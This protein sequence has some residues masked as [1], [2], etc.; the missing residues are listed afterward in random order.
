MADQ[1]RLAVRDATLDDFEAWLALFEAVAAE[2][3]WIGRESPLDR[4]DR[5]QAFQ[6]ALASDDSATLLAEIDGELVGMLGIGDHFGRAELGMMVDARW[7]GRGVGSK[8]MEAAIAWA[9]ARGAHKISLEV[10]PHNV[11]ARALYE[12]FGFAEEAL[13]RRHYRRRNGELWDAVEMGLVLDEQ[14]PGSPFD[15]STAS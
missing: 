9:N 8:L 2:G 6:Q 11:A 1:G 14:S 4:Q 13:L 12:K 10:W 3:R 15:D 5:E 7:R